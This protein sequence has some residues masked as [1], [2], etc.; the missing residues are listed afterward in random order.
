MDALQ[1][2]Q[3]AVAWAD[4]IICTIAQYALKFVAL[5]ACIFAMVWIY[6]VRFRRY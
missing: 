4:I 6:L 1:N 3:I 5:F 2:I